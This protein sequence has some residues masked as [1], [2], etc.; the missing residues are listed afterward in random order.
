VLQGFQCG[1]QSH[2]PPRVVKL[3]PR[4]V[5]QRRCNRRTN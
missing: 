4:H 1:L 3:Q 2:R 5:L